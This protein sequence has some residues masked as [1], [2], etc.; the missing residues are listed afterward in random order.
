MLRI[1]KSRRDGTYIVYNPHN[2][3]DCH[4][5]CDHLRVAILIKNNVEKKRIPTSTNPKTLESHLRVTRDRKYKKAIQD[6]LY[7]YSA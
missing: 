2:F 4:T 3:E 6:I 7:Q 1:K 5:H